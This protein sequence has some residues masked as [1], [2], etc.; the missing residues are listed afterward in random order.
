MKRFFVLLF[1]CLP[2]V[3]QPKIVYSKSFP[4]SVPPFV[5][6]T[7]ESDGKA[8]YMESADDDRPV[9][10]RLKQEQ[11]DVIFALAVKLDKFQKPLESGLKVANMGAKTF[12]WVEGTAAPAEAK[13]NYSQDV[14]AQALQDWFEK[15]SESANHFMALERTVRYDKLGVNQVLLLFNAAYDRGRILGLEQFLPLL[16]RVIKNDGYLNMD[17]E[18]AGNLAAAIRNP[19]PA[20]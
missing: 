19:A 15:M 10:F 6:I 11:A 17:R 1:L 18:R 13:Y 14:D 9:R 16:D 4:G 12:R 2:L 7:L 20:R 3:A 5:Q 8:E